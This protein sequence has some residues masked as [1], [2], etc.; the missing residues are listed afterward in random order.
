[1]NWPTSSQFAGVQIKSLHAYHSGINLSVRLQ[2]LPQRLRRNV[3][4]ARNRGM[5]MPG[6]KLWLQSSGERSFVHALVDL[7]QMWMRL[8]NANPDNFW[9]AFCG[10]R[11]DAS[12]G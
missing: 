4:A 2:K 1:M 8:A 9:S 11:S 7:K 10:E 3:S 12:D 6:T 5:R